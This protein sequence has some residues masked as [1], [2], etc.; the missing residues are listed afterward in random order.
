MKRVSDGKFVEMEYNKDK[1]VAIR[2]KNSEFYFLAWMEDAEHYQIQKATN[3]NGYLLDRTGLIFNGD[4]Y[5]T[6]V[7]TKEYNSMYMLYETDDD[8]NLIHED[9]KQ[10]KNAYEEFLTL[11]DCYK[12]NGVSDEE[13]HDIFI[14]TKE[15]LCA[16]CDALRDG[17]YVLIVTDMR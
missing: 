5:D 15:E 1:I 2:I 7:N 16:V 8:G 14:L 12:R 13:D 10:F 11:V 4:I 17:D 3:S 9:E 6:I